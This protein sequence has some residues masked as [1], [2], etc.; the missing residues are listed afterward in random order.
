[1]SGEF[2]QALRTADLAPGGMKAVDVNG[3][4]VVICNRGGTFHAIDRRCG[5]MNAPLEMGTLD[6]D[7]VT[8]PMHCAQ[9]DIMTGEA[10][11]GPV[12]GDSGDEVPPPRIAALLRNVALLMQHVRTE[13]IATFEVKTESG[14]VWVALPAGPGSLE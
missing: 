4:E 5:H 14:W 9:F 6:G 10:L 13:P 3:R 2:V 12:P 8:C 7:I 1:L 11:S